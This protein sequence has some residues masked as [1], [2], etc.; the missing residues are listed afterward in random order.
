MLLVIINE[1]LNKKILVLPNIIKILDPKDLPKLAGEWKTRAELTTG[2][3]ETQRHFTWDMTINYDS[4]EQRGA[5]L[6]KKQGVEAKEIMYYSENEFFSIHDNQCEFSKLTDNTNPNFFGLV[7]TQQDDL[8]ILTMWEP[9]D[10]L[11]FNNGF[12]HVSLLF[13]N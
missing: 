10:V 11:H 8:T 1:I 7:Q 2:S 3:P 9:N 5:I 6:F 4:F 12:N 13:K